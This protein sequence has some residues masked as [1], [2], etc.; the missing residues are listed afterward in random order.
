MAKEEHSRS[1]AGMG[2]KKT[3]SKKSGKKPH[4]LEIH[5][6]KSGGFIVHHHFKNDA[7]EMPEEPEQHVVPDLNSLQSHIADNMGDQGPAPTPSPDV[8]QGQPAPA[9]GP[10]PAPAAQGPA[11]SM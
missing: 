11:P 9:A 1:K 5:R 8:S 2:G 3:S 4:H 6:G 10:A 7:G